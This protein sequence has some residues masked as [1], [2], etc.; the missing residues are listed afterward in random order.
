[1]ESTSGT[2]P[3]DHDRGL[4]GPIAGMVFAVLFVA[5]WLVG[6]DTPRYD[7]G[8]QAWTA[9]FDNAGNRARHIFS[10]FAMTVGSLAFVV[11]LWGLVRRLRR[12]SAEPDG[13][14]WLAMGAGLLVAALTIVAGITIAAASAAIEFAPNDFPVPSP[15]VLRMTEQLGIGI[16]LLG[17]GL[18]AAL[19]VAASSWSARGTAALPGWLVV[20]GYVVAVLLLGSITFVALVLLPLWVLVVSITMLSSRPRPPGRAAS[21]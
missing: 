5:G 20:A 15:D 3:E 18:S 19:F 9:W 1:M 8:D 10:A 14:A 13:P 11:F 17:G 21:A 7:A 16:G 4:L 6:L 2:R 12:F